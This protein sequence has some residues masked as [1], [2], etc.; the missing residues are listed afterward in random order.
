[1][2]QV[3]LVRLRL[4]TSDI[5]SCLGMFDSVFGVQ[6]TLRDLGPNPVVIVPLGSIELEL[7]QRGQP[8]QGSGTW[9]FV[10]VRD[11][12]AVR[13]RLAETDM[14]ILFGEEQGTRE[15]MFRDR[16]G[17]GWWVQQDDG[18]NREDMPRH[19]DLPNGVNGH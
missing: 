12:A 3:M 10:V 4:N 15:V 11:L 1:M 16:D 6:P 2:S 7:I 14:R 18:H 19:M 13:Q 5:H 9:L 8:N 17:R